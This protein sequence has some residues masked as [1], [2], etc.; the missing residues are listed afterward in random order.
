MCRAFILT[1]LPMAAFGETSVKPEAWP[2]GLWDPFEWPRHQQFYGTRNDDLGSHSACWRQRV[3][4][5]A[6]FILG[7]PGPASGI[8][9]LCRPTAAG[10]KVDPEENHLL[11]RKF[12]S[13]T[14]LFGDE[15]IRGLGEESAQQRENNQ[16]PTPPGCLPSPCWLSLSWQYL[17]T[18][19]T[20]PGDRLASSVDRS[21]LRDN[22]QTD[23]LPTLRGPIRPC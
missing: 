4:S 1:I 2:G 8:G 12:Q 14:R 5:P 7:M 21:A 15:P 11:P 3:R 19:K 10:N 16:C 23:Q 20:D 6:C 17:R 13:G 22:Q 18:E 9:G